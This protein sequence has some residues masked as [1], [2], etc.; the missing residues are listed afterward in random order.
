MRFKVGDT[1]RVIDVPPGTNDR[2]YI[3][4]VYKIKNIWL[5]GSI[6]IDD[7]Y[8]WHENCFELVS[9]NEMEEIRKTIDNILDIG[10]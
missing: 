4:L 6:N 3:G 5:G 2:S 1:V 8:R 10:L 7:C 9:T